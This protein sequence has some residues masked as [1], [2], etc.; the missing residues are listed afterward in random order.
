MEQIKS[1]INE[2]ISIFEKA[3]KLCSDNIC[4]MISLYNDQIFTSYF[5]NFDSEIKNAILEKIDFEVE[6]L[7]IS[8]PQRNVFR[9]NIQFKN[10][11]VGQGNLKEVKVS[12]NIESRKNKIEKTINETKE[13]ISLML[14]EIEIHKKKLNSKTVKKEET[15]NEFKS[16]I[17]KISANIDFLKSEI[18]RLNDEL[19]ILEESEKLVKDWESKFLEFGFSPS[20][21]VKESS[22][23]SFNM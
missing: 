3:K 12:F 1:F 4:D 23:L 17:G 21:L 16:K 18:T 6:T 8:V 22:V 10:V 2:Q 5:E 14:N 20:N 13:R 15:K 9:F 11:N 19:I 7:G